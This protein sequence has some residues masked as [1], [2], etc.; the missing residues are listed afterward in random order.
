MTTVCKVLFDNE[1]AEYKGVS[2]L[3]EKG[4]PVSYLGERRYMISEDDCLAL[5]SKS[6]DYALL[7]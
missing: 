3:K 7:E 2:V 5:K 4:S 1:D 6:V